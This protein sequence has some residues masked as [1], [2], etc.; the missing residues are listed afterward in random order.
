MLAAGQGTRLQPLTNGTPKTL[1]EVSGRPILDHI[2]DSLEK[3]GYEEVIVVT[4]FESEQIRNHCE[5]RAN[6]G[7]EFEFVHSD[8]FASTNNIYSLWLAREYAAGGFTLINSD[9][10][11][12]SQSL[13]KLQQKDGS[14][15]LTD[16]E[17][18]LGDEEMKVALENGYVEEIG[19]HLDEADAE[20]TGVSKFS[21][22]DAPSLFERI[23][24]FIEHDDVNEWYESAFDDLFDRTAVEHVSV[25]KPWI[26]IDT[27]ADL[28]L[29]RERWG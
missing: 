5:P 18:E 21:A 4:G 16:T 15:L 3:N 14:A 25:Q 29:A 7:L 24:R 12:P 28:E 9:T 11:V 22:E 23:H 20:Y 10:L 13:G 2:L 26:E 27:P 19:K 8:R 17:K 6:S 1:L